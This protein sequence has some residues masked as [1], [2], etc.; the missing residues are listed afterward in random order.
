MGTGA[1][2]DDQATAPPS[3]LENGITTWAARTSDLVGITD[4]A[5]GLVWIN[6]AGRRRLGLD[7]DAVIT[8][9]DLLPPS[10][11]ALY[12]DEIRP[13]VLAGGAWSGELTMLSRSGPFEAWATI[14]GEAD[15]GGDVASLIVVA[16]DLTELRTVQRE[17]GHLAT[18]DELTG[19]ANRALLG[20][21]LD[22]A[23]AR[24]VRNGT[25]LAVVYVDLDGLK[26]VNDTLGH[27]AGD[28]LLREAGRRMA[29]AVRP[30][31]LVAR[32]GG[33]E[34][35]L[36]LEGLGTREEALDVAG[37][38]RLA[39]EADPVRTAEM[40]IPLS[41]S[42][43]VAWGRG[44]EVAGDVLLQRADTAM[45]EAKLDRSR[46][47]AVY[48]D[49]LHERELHRAA[50]GDELAI[51]ITQRRVRPHYLGVVD[52]VRG[53]RVGWHALARWDHPE[54]GVL[55]ADEFV[56]AVAGAGAATALDLAVL[57]E[58]AGGAARLPGRP[59]PRID[60]SVSAR[61]LAEPSFADLVAE[62]LD[63][64]GLARGQL[65]I[66]IPEAVLARDVAPV[67]RTLAAL[68]DLDVRLAAGG[69][70]LGA[71]AVRSIVDVGITEFVLARDLVAGLPAS[72]HEVIAGVIGLA[73]GLG[74]PTTAVGVA[75]GDQLAALADLG[76]DLA[77]GH[78]FG[79]PTADAGA[80]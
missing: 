61:S 38:V 56:D 59:R 31:D 5:G 47:I 53:R 49:D 35:V 58:A 68:R 48:D 32:V 54:R 45:Y 41:A 66:R 80:A 27:A 63:A 13:V 43:G 14:V 6:D 37:R 12:F 70:G 21:A 50:L 51:A 76:C 67:A 55:D 28:V 10:A 42:F 78:H 60:V 17:L 20:A 22:R 15:A 8:T 46:A 34:F 77:E 30:S 69:V 2:R 52:V 29:R 44:A 39:L 75:S 71:L 57:R 73:H 4:D 16:R 26:G 36:L 25:T 7:V 18:H 23:L 72:G 74:L 1:R 3:A 62:V 33:D 40:P 65:G 19:L 64:T 9:A 24:S 79:A 11:F